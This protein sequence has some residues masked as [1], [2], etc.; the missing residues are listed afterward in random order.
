MTIRFAVLCVVVCTILMVWADFSKADDS[1]FADA[2]PTMV[3]EEGAGEGPAWDPKLG[4][5]FSGH[6]GITRLDLEGKVTVFREMAGTNGLL[7]DARG[8]LLSCVPV[9][10][11]VSRT[12]PDGSLVVLAEK[13][14]GMRFN[15]PNDITVDSKGRIYFSDPKYGPRTNMEMLD[16]DGKQV[17]G[18]YR[19]DLDG[20]V[21]RVITHEAD[22]PNGVFVTPDD[23][24]LY[25]ADN[26]NNDRGGARKLWRFRLKK[27]GDLKLKSRKLIFDWGDGRGPDGMVLD[28]AGRLYV[29]G[30]LNKSRAPIETNKL[31]GGVYVFSADGKKIDF[32]HIPRD[33]VTNCTFGGPDLKTLYV[34]AGGTLWSIRTKTAGATPWPK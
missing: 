20:K 13:F 22:R 12:E 21:S 11:H 9:Q 15:Q 33:E 27:N 7:F 3:L 32:V 34:T 28:A 8:R 29:A 6:L 24:W 26:N 25:V 10:R 23:K 16:E 14:D 30:G 19:I 18:V 2:K 4:L 31:L 17:E 5:L 1:V